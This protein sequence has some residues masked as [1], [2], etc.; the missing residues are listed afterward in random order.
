MKVYLISDTHFN[1]D[2]IKTYCQRPDDFT[3]RIIR[4]WKSIV[5]PNDLVLHLG[6]VIIGR[7]QALPDIIAQLPGHKILVIGNHDRQHSATWWMQNGFE[8]ACQA[9]VFRN[10]WL[11]HEPSASL[12]NGC[13][14][15]VHGH[16]HNFTLEVHPEYKPKSFHRLFALEYTNYRPVEFDKFINHPE[17]YKAKLF[18]GG[19]V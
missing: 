7:R 1:H 16:L 13:A 9:M 14:L 6:D 18:S 10:V 5:K 2:N 11:T 15:N 3:T 4:E 12:A 17:K 8:F 19:L